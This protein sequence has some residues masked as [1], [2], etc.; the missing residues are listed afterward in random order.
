MADFTTVTETPNIRVTREALA[1]AY[2]R[3]AFAAQ[4]SKGKRVL[5]VACGVGQGLG[6]IARV[7]RSVVGGDVSPGLLRAA[8]R[9]YQGRVPLALFDAQSLPFRAGAFDVVILYEAI[10]YLPAPR[11]FVAEACRVLSAGGVLLICTVNPQWR[12]FNPSPMSTRYFGAP[13]LRRLLEEHGLRASLYAAFPATENSPRRR[14]VSGLKRAAVAL[15]LVPRTMKG[16]QLLK[17]LFF[18][19]L[20]AAPAEISEGMAPHLEPVPISDETAAGRSKV[21]FARGVKREDGGPWSS[22]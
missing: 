2:T 6:Y 17:R 15:D 12:D 13:E 4:F 14:I 10:Y 7:A 9:H 19:P 18:G 8:S 22:T 5:E 16:K 1:M 3:Y 21:L 11:S 20:V